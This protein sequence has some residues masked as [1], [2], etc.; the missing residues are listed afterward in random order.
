M[1]IFT[2]GYEKRSVENF[3]DIL[4]SEGVTVVIDVR[5]NPV[6]RKKGFSKKGLE[7]ILKGHGI[8]YLHI[9]ELGA[10]RALRDKLSSD[11]DYLS[12]FEEYK[13][14]ITDRLDVIRG[15][16]D[17]LLKEYGCLM[18]YEEQAN[19]CHRSQIAGIIA[20]MSPEEVRI[21]HL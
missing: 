18:C 3:L 21:E 4:K 7:V 6:S 5:A 12:F 8:E 2:L 19:N 17:R 20:T 10:P 15:L 13:E 11:G 16:I 1:V 9:K 14:L